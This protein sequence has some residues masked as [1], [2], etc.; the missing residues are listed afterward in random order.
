[1]SSILM[2]PEATSSQAG[3]VTQLSGFPW[4]F[5]PSLLSEFVHYRHLFLSARVIR[6]VTITQVGFMCH[7]FMHSKSI[8][9]G[10]CVITWVVFK[11]RFLQIFVISIEV[12]SQS[13]LFGTYRLASVTYLLSLVLCQSLF[14]VLVYLL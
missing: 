5:L 11:H 8:F 2:R 9:V 12:L 7:I 14:F 6:F 4:R 13:T 1:M 10:A 3:E